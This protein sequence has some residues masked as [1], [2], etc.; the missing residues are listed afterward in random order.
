MKKILSI[1][2]DS[3]TLITEMEDINSNIAGNF[4][5]FFAKQAV[6]SGALWDVIKQCNRVSQGI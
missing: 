5:R 3:W 2:D 4:Q 6:N 1:Q